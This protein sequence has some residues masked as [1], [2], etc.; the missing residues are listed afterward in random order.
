MGGEGEARELFAKILHHVVALELAMHEHVETDVFLPAHRAGGLV[1]Q[2]DFV[3]LVRQGALAC[4]ARA[5]LTS[6]VCGNEP[7]VVVGKGGRLKRSR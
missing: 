1:L 4:A 7:I 3:G 5:F 6:A 2:I